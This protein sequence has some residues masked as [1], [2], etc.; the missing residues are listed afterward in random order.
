MY[1]DEYKSRLTAEV[2]AELEKYIKHTPA[3]KLPSRLRKELKQTPPIVALLPANTYQLTDLAEER[4]LEFLDHVRMIYDDV[5]NNNPTA[6]KVNSDQL[7]PAL[8]EDEA[9]LLGNA[10]AT[11][12]GYCCKHGKTHA[13]VDYPSLKHL[14]ASQPTELSEPALLDLYSHYFH[15]QSYH[16]SCVFQGNKGCTLPRELRSFTCNNF[17]CDQLINYRYETMK[18]DSTLTFAAAVDKDTIMFTSVYNNEHFI[19]MKQKE[20]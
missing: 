9:Q 13:F 4:K 15:K 18:S 1:L 12:M 6:H 3:R 7:Y 17:L 5:E 19:R 11:C 20:S 14:L 2:I 8:Q 16:D 10:C